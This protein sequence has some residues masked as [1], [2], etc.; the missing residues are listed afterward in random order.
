MVRLRRKALI[1]SPAPGLYVA[2]PPEFRSWGAVPAVDFI[3]P[4]M[5]SMGRRYY[6]ALLS[7]AQLHGAAHQQP[8]VLQVMVDEQVSD[9]DFGRVKVRFA[10][11]GRVGRVPTQRRNARTGSFELSSRE[12]TALDLATRPKEGGGLSNVATV[13]V[14]LAEDRG[15]DEALIV[16]ASR[17]YPV[18]SLRRLGWLLEH[19]H[20]PVDVD[21]LAA[22]LPHT[23]ARP[24]TLLQPG[25]PRR[26]HGNHRWGVV[27]NAELESDL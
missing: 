1:F 20:A 2:V 21:V 14:E 22:A 17:L 26:G 6:V 13:L 11:S 27:E 23:E 8:Q 9:R 12:V 10:S 7:A 15:L 4:M 16:E 3:D 24:E 18:S 5:A 19:V 25:G